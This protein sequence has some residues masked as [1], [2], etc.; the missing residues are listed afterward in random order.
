[1]SSR[2][3]SA[4]T[5]GSAAPPRHGSSS[6]EHRADAED[7]RADQ[8]GVRD[9]VREGAVHRVHQG[10]RLPRAR[11]GADVLGDGEARAWLLD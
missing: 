4:A 1:M 9:G 8:A 10:L 3:S 6:D 7:H 11:L 5:C 2:S